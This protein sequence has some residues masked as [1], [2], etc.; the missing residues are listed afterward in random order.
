[1]TYGVYGLTFD[2]CEIPAENVLGEENRGFHYAVLGLNEARVNV[3]CQ[4]LGGS[5][6]AFEHALQYSKDRVTFGQPLPSHQVLQHMLADM[7]MDQHAARMLLLEAAWGW[8]S[9]VDVRPKSS[10]AK[11]FCTEVA[12]RIADKDLQ[13]FGGA[14]YFKGMVVE[15]VYR[16]L[17]VMRIFEGANEIQRNMLTKQLLKA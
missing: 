2:N 17:R 7:A 10:Y 4:A 16:E 13:F 9:G 6:I 14:G 15:R 5:Q 12:N 3:G 11:V 1:M 8:E